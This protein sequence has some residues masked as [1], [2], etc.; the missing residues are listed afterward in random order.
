MTVK[1][2]Q[3]DAL[4]RIVTLTDLRHKVISQNLANVNT[5]GYTRLDVSFEDVASWFSSPDAA[6]AGRASDQT[7]RVV[8][9]EA[10]SARAD[11]NNVDVD[12]ELGQLEENELLQQ[13]LI[14]VLAKKLAMMQSAISGR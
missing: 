12:R 2:S 9:D 6:T 1:P 13:T 11:G 3:F 7:D 5:P 8:R 14:Q 4:H 10:L